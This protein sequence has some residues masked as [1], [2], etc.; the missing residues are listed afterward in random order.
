MAFGART[1]LALGGKSNKALGAG[2]KKSALRWVR[3][4]YE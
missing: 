2:Q 3:K 1:N 4:F